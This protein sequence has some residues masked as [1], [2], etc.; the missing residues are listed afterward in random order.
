M[1]STCCWIWEGM[2]D[3]MRETML[4]WNPVTRKHG[5]FGIKF[6][7]DAKFTKLTTQ[8]KFKV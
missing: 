2:L 5:G 6:D 3:S 8:V 1:N 4:K 7:E